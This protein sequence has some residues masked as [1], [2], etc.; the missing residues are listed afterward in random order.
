MKIIIGSTYPFLFVSTFKSN[1][2]D[3]PLYIFES[4]FAEKEGKDGLRRDYDVGFA[5]ESLWLTI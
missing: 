2:D 1:R 4:V 3:S 5:S